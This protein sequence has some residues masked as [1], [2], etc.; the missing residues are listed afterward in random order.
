L[1]RVVVV[2]QAATEQLA[3]ILFYKMHRLQL[4]PL[5]VAVVAAII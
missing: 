4:P 1:E 5:V 2:A 3:A